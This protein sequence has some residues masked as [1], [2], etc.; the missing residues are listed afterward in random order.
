MPQRR[1]AAAI[2]VFWILGCTGNAPLD[3]PEKDTIETTT[4]A[5]REHESAVSQGALWNDLGVVRPFSEHDAEFVVSNDSESDW[6]L[7]DHTSS[8]S[9]AVADLDVQT[10]R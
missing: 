8:C 4:E 9:C 10:L 2:V 1:N 5:L 7:I 6:T 3:V